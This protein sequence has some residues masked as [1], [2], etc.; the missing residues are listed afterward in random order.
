MLI[1]QKNN[2]AK[3][4]NNLS[5]NLL[6]NIN[7]ESK[8]VLFS[9]Y[10]ISNA[11]A[12]TYVG[13]K[14]STKLEMGKIL[15]PYNENNISKGFY[16]LN[17][18]LGFNKK[19]QLFSANAIWLENAYKL[20]KV[21]KKIIAEDFMSKVNKANFSTKKGREK[22]KKEINSWVEKTT[23]GKIADFLTPKVLSESTTLVLVNAI[24]FYSNWDVKFAKANTYKAKFET[25][26][27]NISE[28]DYMTDTS[29]FLYYSNDLLSAVEIPYQNNEASLIILL[30]NNASN[31]LSDL[32]DYQYFAKL[33]PKLKNEKVALHLPKFKLESKYELNSYFKKMGLVSAFK[34]TA[35]FSGITGKKEIHISNVIHKATVEINESGTKASAATAVITT[36]S[37]IIGK[38]TKP[39]LFKAN[40]PFVFLIREK[41]TGT[42]LFIGNLAKP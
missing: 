23:K 11:L 38:K 37:A 27:E 4:I 18:S 13:A 34:P 32:V 41:S 40:H 10:S 24:Y 30:P 15:F 20:K 16:R 35:N 31:N 8:N 1:A 42:I 14:D 29:N 9:A 22:A 5:F 3:N 12:M 6:A 17:E 33:Y 19:I 28:C 26:T 7:T 21:F 25:S 2:T 36:R 39:I